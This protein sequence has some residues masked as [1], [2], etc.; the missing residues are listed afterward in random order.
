MIQRLVNR[1]ILANTNILYVSRALEH[2]IC[3]NFI[4]NAS[5]RS[6][7]V[8]LPEAGKVHNQ[9]RLENATEIES[10]LDAVFDEESIMPRCNGDEVGY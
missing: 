7:N 9:S 6:S 3:Y 1:Y 2:R 4:N 8:T 5:I 10:I